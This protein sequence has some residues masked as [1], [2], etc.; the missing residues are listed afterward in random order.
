MA[1]LRDE[2]QQKCCDMGVYWRAPDAHGVDLTI[3]QAAELLRDALGVEVDIKPP[4]APEGC[5]PADAR[6][7]REANHRMAQELHELK[8]PA[9]E[10]VAEVGPGW[11]LTWAGAEP[12]AHLLARHPSVRIGSKLYAA[13]QP[14]PAPP[15]GDG[16]MPPPYMLAKLQMVMPLFQEAR[17]ALTAITEMQRKLHRIAPDLA[18]RMDAAGTFS[19]DD[20]R[21]AQEL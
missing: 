4:E 8:C 20:W 14:A 15:P 5:T 13:P 6:V 11:L 19:L 10:H 2:L 16:C 17:D 12:L 21:A 1:T 3:E 18:D 7:L 9:T